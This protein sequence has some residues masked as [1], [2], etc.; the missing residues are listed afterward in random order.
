MPWLSIG[1]YTLLAFV[2]AI[3][4]NLIYQLLFRMLNKTRPPLV[5]HWLPFLGSTVHYGTDPYG[6]FFSCRKKVRESSSTYL[7]L[8]LIA[9]YGS[10]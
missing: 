5:F 6:F 7:G 4:L 3:A 1:S 2:A 9:E 8:W 10:I